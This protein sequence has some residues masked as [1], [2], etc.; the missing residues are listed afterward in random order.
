MEERYEVKGKIGQGGLGTVY[1]AHD[2]RMNREV[3]IKA[4]RREF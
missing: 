2:V 1:K 3:A 4:H